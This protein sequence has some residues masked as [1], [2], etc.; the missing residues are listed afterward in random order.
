M[1]DAA[2][3]AYATL[4]GFDPTDLYTLQGMP[5]ELVKSLQESWE[6]HRALY[7]RNREARSGGWA[8]M[9]S[10]R[11]WAESQEYRLYIIDAKIICGRYYAEHSR[12]DSQQD[13]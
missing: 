2:A 8:R 6:R 13:V 9:F 4:M 12:A 3:L 7:V 5:G 1:D 11:Q 10:E